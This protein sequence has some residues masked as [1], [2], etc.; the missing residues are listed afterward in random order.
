MKRIKILGK[1]RPSE[2][3]MNYIK[4]LRSVAVSLKKQECLEIRIKMSY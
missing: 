1:R 3:P 2:T 4:C